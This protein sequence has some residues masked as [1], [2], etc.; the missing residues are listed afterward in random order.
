MSEITKFKRLRTVNITSFK[1]IVDETLTPIYR[2]YDETDLI[3]LESTLVLLENKFSRVSCAQEEIIILIDEEILEEEI[4]KQ[5][6]FEQYACK[7]LSLL[8]NFIKKHTKDEDRS[9]VKSVPNISRRTDNIKLPKIE[10]KRFYG[11]PLEYQAF[12]D[13]FESAVHNN[14]DTGADL[15]YVKP[16]SRLR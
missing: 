8:K 9:C 5:T 6:E 16:G 10:L 2:D 1:K 15:M 7:Q 13:T 4:C 14:K 12:M 3:D 11:D